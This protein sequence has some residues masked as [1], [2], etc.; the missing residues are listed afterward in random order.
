MYRIK[1][2]GKQL[3]DSDV[4]PTN[5]PSIAPTGCSV[6]TKQGFSIIK[7]TGPNDTNNHTVPHG[8]SQEPDFIITKNLDAT[9]NWDIYHSCLLYTSPSPRDATLSRMPSS[10]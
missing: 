5:V 8:L 2:G 9:F 6:G 4:T 7:Y 10:A 1:V 3:I